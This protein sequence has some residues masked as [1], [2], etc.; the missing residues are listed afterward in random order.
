M[1]LIFFLRPKYYH[2]AGIKFYEDIPWK[3]HRKKCRKKKKKCRDHELRLKEV[4]L[5]LKALREKY[6]DNKDN[7]KRF[8]LLFMILALEDEEKAL[9]EWL[10]DA[11]Y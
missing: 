8:R 9:E 4:A 5:E 6:E 10:D 2:N 3:K 7:D 1:T 11:I